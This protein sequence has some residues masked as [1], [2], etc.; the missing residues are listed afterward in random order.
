MTSTAAS[1]TATAQSAALATIAESSSGVT[2][3]SAARAEWNVYAWPVASL[4]RRN[5]SGSSVSIVVLELGTIRPIRLDSV[6]GEGVDGWSWF[7]QRFSTSSDG[8]STRIV[9]SQPIFRVYWCAVN[10]S[11]GLPCPLIR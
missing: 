1:E 9:G 4:W 8:L 7:M 11:D 10:G 5:N 2:F 3:L 6:P